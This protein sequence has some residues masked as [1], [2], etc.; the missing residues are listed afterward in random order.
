M[1]NLTL[2]ASSIVVSLTSQPT[3]GMEDST[4]SYWVGYF[5]GSG[6]ALEKSTQQLNDG[7]VKVASKALYDN[8]NITLIDWSFNEI[9]DRGAQYLAKLLE[10]NTTITSLDVSTNKIGN[11][12]A[13]ALAEALKKNSTLL[14]LFLDDNKAIGEEGAQ[15][16]I[17]ALSSN[18]TV[19]VYLKSPLISQQTLASINALVK[20]NKESRGQ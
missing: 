3:W 9:T 8:D 11:E 16:I 19:A 13:K 17:D 2:L 4:D 10:H 6:A 5:K 14:N 7:Y 12:G 18:T 1:K 20:R 15:A